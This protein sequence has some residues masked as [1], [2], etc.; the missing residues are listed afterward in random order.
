MD[1]EFHYYQSYLIAI[2]SGFTPADACIFAYA[3]QH[4]DDNDIIFEI[5]K[6]NSDYF[7]NYIS[8]TMNILKP[9]SKL[10]RIYPIFHF[11][12]GDPMVDPARRKDGRMQL[13]NTTPGSD[14][15]HMIFDKAAVSG[16]LYRIGIAAHGFVDTW[17]HQ[18]FTGY[19][20]DFNAMK[21][22]LEQ[23]TPNIGHADAQHNP[24][25]PGLVWK[26]LRL[27][28]EHERIDNRSRFL[29]AAVALHKKLSAIARPGIGND[30]VAQEGKELRNNLSQVMFERDPNNHLKTAR[31]ERCLDLAQQISYGAEE[32]PDY[33]ADLWFEEVVIENVRGLRDRNESNHF[34][35]KVFADEYT[36]K[37]TA[38]YRD[39]HWYRFQQAVIRH[40]DETKEILDERVFGRMELESL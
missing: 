10:L 31:I 26:D 6:D 40:Q 37:D 4:V 15:A 23:A 22:V 16:D 29:N 34:G 7:S 24:D 32:L 18:N 20:D 5:N 17:A 19:F 11:I 38:T 1:I 3:S 12:P 33:D 2:K 8:Q 25:W 36:W 14:N 30:I 27:V 21:G 39:K 9:K 13:L 28:S 35:L